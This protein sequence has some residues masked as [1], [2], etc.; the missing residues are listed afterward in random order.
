MAAWAAAS[1]I[2]NL[3]PPPSAAPPALPP[4]LPVAAVPFILDRVSGELVFQGEG[5][6]ALGADQVDILLDEHKIGVGSVKGG[7]G[8]SFETEAGQHTVVLMLC[9]GTKKL[10][11]S[12]AAPKQQFALNLQKPGH[13]TVTFSYAQPKSFVER[14]RA[15]NPAGKGLPTQ[16]EIAYSPQ[17]KQLPR[18]V[19]VDPGTKPAEQETGLV[20]KGLSALGRMFTLDE[21]KIEQQVAE[22]QKDARRGYLTGLWQPVSGKGHSYIFTDDGGLKRSDGLCRKFRWQSEDKL[23]LYEEGVAKPIYFDIISL[24]EHELLLK[25]DEGAVHYKNRPVHHRAAGPR[26]GILRRAVRQRSPRQPD[27]PL[28]T[29]QRRGQLVPLY[30]GP[31]DAACRWSE[32]LEL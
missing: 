15:K 26:P 21:K 32:T 31:G 11:G 17:V 20:Q 24:G 28:G 18:A 12:G 30:R 16:T 1:T 2:P 14:M 5:G 27:R 10:F 19:K 23:E 3:F 7:F 25:T 29:R 6:M 22:I 9:D 4:A 13:Y 8:V